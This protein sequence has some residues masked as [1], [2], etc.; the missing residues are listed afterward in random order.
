MRHFVVVGGSEFQSG[1]V[2]AAR[3]KGF[4]V[5]VV[6]K[7]LDCYCNNHFSEI[8]FINESV[9]NVNKVLDILDQFEVIGAATVQS[10]YGVVLVEAIRERFGIVK[11]QSKCAE[12]LTN[13]YGFKR[14]LYENNISE[15]VPYLINGQVGLTQD[16]DWNIPRVL[17]PNDSSGSRGVYFV[18]SLD[19]F[20]SNLPSALK[21]SFSNTAI[22]EEQL[23]GIEKGAQVIVQDVDNYIVINHDDVL[24]GQVPV[25]HRKL[26]ENIDLNQKI[27]LLI[28]KLGLRR[29]IL[30]IDYFESS[31]GIEFIEVGMRLGATQLDDLVTEAIGRNVYDIIIENY[32]VKN[33]R[34]VSDNRIKTHGVLFNPFISTVDLANRGLEAGTTIIFK[35]IEV[36]LNLDSNVRLVKNMTSG[37][38]RFG[39]FTANGIIEDVEE[40]MKQ[41]LN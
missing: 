6:D 8:F 26:Q 40:L 37:I 5:I 23:F 33:L 4:K 31:M 1:L 2:N 29:C 30:N 7:N 20:K 14:F 38:D 28:A 10:D 24:Y 36:S 32:D 34:R 25:A 16:I 22:L 27:G 18:D 41:I 35:G 12:I 39:S 9:R 15:K 19:K 3:R 17:K 21:H 11:N 13:K